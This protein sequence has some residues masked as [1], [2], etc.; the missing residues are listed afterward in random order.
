[1]KELQ[2]PNKKLESVIKDSELSSLA[3]DYTELALDGII[4]DSALKEIPLVGTVI[5]VVKFGNSVNEYLFAKKIYKFLFQL[6][7]IPLEKRIQK[8][9]QINSSK[10]YQSKVGEKIFELLDKID[11]DGKPEILGKLFGAVIEEKI[12]FLNYLRA[13]HIIKNIFYYD[14]VEL[15][16]HYDGRW[17]HGGV[18]DEIYSNGIVDVDYTISMKEAENDWNNI[19]REDK[20]PD[21]KLSEIGD[22][23]I[24]IG[25]S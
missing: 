17:I 7:K 13:A 8:I 12:D 4:D 24:N 9:D 2:N 18:T 1:M 5:G 21:T 23:I 11:S 25:M 15:K 16:S 22:I 10:K 20:Y 3:K 19:P 6:H 14:L